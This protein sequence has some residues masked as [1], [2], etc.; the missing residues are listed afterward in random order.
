[1]NHES[2]APQFKEFVLQ[3][4]HEGSTYQVEAMERLY[5]SDQ[6]ILFFNR[7]GSFSPTSRARMLA[8]FTARRDSG[9]PHL[10]TEHRILHVEQQ[11]A[12][13]RSR[14]CTAE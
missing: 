6:S 7:D 10:S 8:E 9:E 5:P 12:L 1:M 4:V 14:S 11:G 3:V 2:F 13:T